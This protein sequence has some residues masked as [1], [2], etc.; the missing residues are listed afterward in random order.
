MPL[1]KGLLD[2][3]PTSAVNS[4]QEGEA[5]HNKK[6][7]LPPMEPY[8]DHQDD[9]LPPG[10]AM[11]SSVRFASSSKEDNVLAKFP[12]PRQMIKQASMMAVVLGQIN[13]AH[14]EAC[15]ELGGW[16]YNQKGLY[17][18]V[19]LRGSAQGVLGNMPKGSNA[20]LSDIGKSL[21]RRICTSKSNRV[22][23]GAD[24]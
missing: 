16:K 13:H 10:I 23:Q 1:Q 5:A 24:A 4:Y 6:H 11:R 21:G 8:R 15:A 20:R 22:I 17:L 14:F 19:S 12:V 9:S 7:G 2:T 3:I 18:A